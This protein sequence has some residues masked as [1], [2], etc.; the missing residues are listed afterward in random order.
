MTDHIDRLA[1]VVRG[2]R[3]NTCA[4]CPPILQEA[5]ANT[6]ADSDDSPCEALAEA[7]LSELTSLARRG[8]RLEVAAVAHM[9]A[10]DAMEEAVEY[11][12]EVLYEEQ[13]GQ[14]VSD[15]WKQELSEKV[16][17]ANATEHRTA[18]KLRAALDTEGE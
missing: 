8:E 17:E 7:A 3:C 9:A 2:F 18:D 11:R 15:Q 16:R 6:P 12:R 4:E 13:H 1:G 10:W 5:W 14:V